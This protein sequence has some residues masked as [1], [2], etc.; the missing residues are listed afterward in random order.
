M[1]TPPEADVPQLRELYDVLVHCV[2]ATQPRLYA[3]LLAA[4]SRAAGGRNQSSLTSRC[5]LCVTGSLST[6]WHK[7]SSCMQ[8]RHLGNL[9]RF[10]HTG[11]YSL[12]SSGHACLR[13]H[14]SCCIESNQVRC[15]GWVSARDSLS[16]SGLY[17]ELQAAVTECM[18]VQ[19]VGCGTD[20]R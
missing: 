8:N 1:D 18:L 7:H 12:C 3:H 19:G 2:P 6:S 16:L 5:S 20:G 13:S 14:A 10:P 15:G 17:S 4:C 9:P 11:Q